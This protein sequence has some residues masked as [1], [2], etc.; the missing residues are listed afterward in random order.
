M[1]RPAH[2]ADAVGE[3]VAR[4]RAQAGDGAGLVPDAACI[5]VQRAGSRVVVA[6]LGAQQASSD[7][8][9]AQ[10][11]TAAASRSASRAHGKS[12]SSSWALVRLR[13]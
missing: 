6:V 2:A 11:W 4:E 8:H 13:L 5:P 12:R 3:D 7:R 10:A 9:G 1:E